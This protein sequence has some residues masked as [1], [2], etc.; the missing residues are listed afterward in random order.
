[1]GRARR[2][3]LCAEQGGW[4][5]EVERRRLTSALRT[6]SYEETSFN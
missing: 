6:D 4:G 2:G 3:R 1:M 5:R